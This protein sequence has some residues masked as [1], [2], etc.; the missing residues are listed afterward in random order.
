VLGSIGAWGIIAGAL[1]T[2]AS[3]PLAYAGGPA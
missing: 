1:I 2:I 3:K